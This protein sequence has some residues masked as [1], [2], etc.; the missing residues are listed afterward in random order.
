MLAVLK[1]IVSINAFATIA[2]SLFVD[3]GPLFTQLS[4]F[5]PLFLEALVTLLFTLTVQHTVVVLKCLLKVPGV[6]G[7]LLIPVILVFKQRGQYYWIKI[8]AASHHFIED[9][10]I[11]QQHQGSFR[12][13]II[14]IKILIKF[15]DLG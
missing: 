3:L 2:S 4:L 10:V 14:V 6:F 11:L 13:L 1:A 12:Y 8:A 9:L 15:R 7:N 5:I